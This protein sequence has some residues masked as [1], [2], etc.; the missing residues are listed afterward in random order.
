MLP[1]LL[2][3]P[4]KLRD[5]L[6]ELMNYTRMALSG[7][8]DPQLKHYVQIGFKEL[9]PWLMPRSRCD[10]LEKFKESLLSLFKA[11]YLEPENVKPGTVEKC[12]RWWLY[13]DALF[14]LK[15]LL[16]TPIRDRP[17]QEHKHVL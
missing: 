7:I 2:R 10:S 16:E 8:L 3:A 15:R 9:K 12:I 14:Y 1:Y 17:L 6:V 4:P 13:H 11:F 5:R